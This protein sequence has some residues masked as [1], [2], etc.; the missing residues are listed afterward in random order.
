M[1]KHKKHDGVVQDV[2]CT[3]KGKD[4]IASV[5]D[6]G[7]LKIWEH[8]AKTEVMEFQGK[9]PYTAVSFGWESDY[10]YFGGIDNIIW[11]YCLRKG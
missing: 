10:V 8:R 3:K 11:K 6:D 9:Y 5:G 1:R 7:R 2:S 4:L